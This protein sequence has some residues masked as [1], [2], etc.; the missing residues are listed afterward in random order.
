MCFQAYAVLRRMAQ[1]FPTLSITV[2]SQTRGAHW[3]LA[4]LQPADEAALLSRWWQGYH[5]ISG[6]LAVS[7]T[8]FWRIADPDRRRVLENTENETAYAFGADVDESQLRAV[9]IDGDGTVVDVRSLGRETER[10]WNELLE[11]LLKR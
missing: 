8:P 7:T 1:R 6:V 10:D 4:P 9:L 2:V 11:I 3:L 5:R